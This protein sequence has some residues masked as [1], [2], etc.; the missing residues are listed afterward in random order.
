[1]N[2]DNCIIEMNADEPPILDGSSLPY[3]QMIA[4]AGIVEQEAEAKYFT[5]DEILYVQGGQT[6]LVL[7][8][9][10]EL[11]ISCLAS[12]AGC[13]VDPQFES[14][15]VTAESYEREL[16]GARTFV[17]YS[18]LQQLLAVGLVKGGSL[19]AAA[20]IH[21]GAIIC[22]EGLRFPDEIVRHKILDLVGDLYLCGRRV[23]ANVIAIKPGHARN[24]ELAG[25]MLKK[26]MMSR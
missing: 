2:V 12:F 20:I 21:N 18:D 19:D 1:M 8:P 10:E 25:L 11:R 13:P 14:L 22:K 9:A 5:T 23:K 7:T 15:T 26:L 24:V 16:A 6:Q 3:F 17:Q 4:D